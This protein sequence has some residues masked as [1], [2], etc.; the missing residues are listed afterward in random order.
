MCRLTNEDNSSG[1][2]ENHSRAPNYLHL[3]AFFPISEKSEI[4]R[5]LL[6]GR[7]RR[8]YAPTEKSSAP[9]INDKCREM[10]CS[11]ALQGVGEASV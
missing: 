3:T 2:Q 8:A 1:I 7:T 4:L 6:C 5:A 9:K 10:V 11:G